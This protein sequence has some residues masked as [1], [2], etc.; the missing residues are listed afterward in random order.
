[1]TA[2]KP[3]QNFEPHADENLS[4]LSTFQPVCQGLRKWFPFLENGLKSTNLWLRQNNS[5][6][7]FALKVEICEE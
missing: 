1:M 2:C 4:H 3:Q 7:Y 6:D 5:K